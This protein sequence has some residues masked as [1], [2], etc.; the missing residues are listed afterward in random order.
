MTI[1]CTKQVQKNNSTNI[2]LLDKYDFYRTYLIKKLSFIVGRAYKKT[3][4]GTHFKAPKLSIEDIEDIVSEALIDSYTFLSKGSFSDGA[5]KSIL[6][7]QLLW[8]LSYFYKNRLNRIYLNS[9]NSLFTMNEDSEQEF[10]GHSDLNN[11]NLK[12]TYNNLVAFN[13][14]DIE[15]DI[16]ICEDFRKEKVGIRKIKAEKKL[17]KIICC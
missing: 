6:N 9:L 17:K 10:I 8:K 16:K 15:H 7:K 1:F 14:G 12:S 5:I 13:Y 4:Q 11:L 3:H 2:S